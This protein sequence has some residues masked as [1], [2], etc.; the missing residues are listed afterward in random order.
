MAL[1]GEEVAE[2][3]LAHLRRRS[4][5]QLLVV[6]AE[7]GAPQPRHAFDIGFA[8]AV[9]DEH[10][11]PALEHERPRVAQRCEIGI[12]VNERLD[13]ADGEVAERGHGRASSL[14]LVSRFRRSYHFAARTLTNV[15]TKGTL[16]TL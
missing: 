14:Q 12:G 16:A 9:I 2:R 8:F 10:A 4:L 5:D 7:R 1:G 15:G 3:Q 13:V 11:A 6:V